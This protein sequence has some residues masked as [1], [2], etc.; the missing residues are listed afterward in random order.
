MRYRSLA[1]LTLVALPALLAACVGSPSAPDMK[2]AD[3]AKITYYPG[4]HVDLS[5]MT[6]TPNGTFYWDSIHGSGTEGAQQSDRVTVHYAL[7]FPDGTLVDNGGG[8][9]LNLR[10]L[11]DS[12]IIG[13]VDGLTGAVEGTTRQ[14]VI[15]PEEGYGAFGS[16][17]GRIPPY[18]TLVFLITVD[19]ITHVSASGTVVPASPPPAGV[20]EVPAL[21]RAVAAAFAAGP[22]PPDEPE[23]T[24]ALAGALERSPRARR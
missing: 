3:P 8:Q 13:W 5:R 10:L 24:R 21:T 23:L 19:K 20:A 7:W 2:W 16:F 14:L 1:A 11:A 17:D 4:L 18:T 12:V 22:P 6:K 15:P 9:A